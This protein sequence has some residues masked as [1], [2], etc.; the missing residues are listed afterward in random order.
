MTASDIRLPLRLAAA[1]LVSTAA[2]VPFA[3][4]FAQE[5]VEEPPTEAETPAASGGDFG[6][7]LLSG[8]R[9]SPEPLTGDWFGARSWLADHG[10]TFGI[11]VVNTVQ[12][13]VG[14]GSNEEWDNGGSAYLESQFSSDRAGL[15]PGGFLDFR[16]ERQYGGFVNKEAGSFPAVN[17]IGLFPEPDYNSFVISKLMATQFAT[18]W[19]GFFIGRF[20]TLDGDTNNLASG[21][22]RTGFL[23]PQLAFSP[24]SALTTPYVLNG[25]GAIVFTPNPLTERP[26]TLSLVFADPQVDPGDSGLNDNFFDE[27]YY[28]VEWRFPTKF[29]GL[30]GSQNI[31][32]N[33]NTKEFLQLDDLTK[34][35]IT[36]EK[37]SDSGTGVI[38]YNFHQYVYVEPGQD[39]ASIGYDADQERLQGFGIFGRVGYSDA[40][41]NPIE[42]SF[43]LG[44][45]G[46]GIIPTRDNDTFGIAPYFG[47]ISR[48][49]SDVSDQLNKNYWG[50][51]AYYN[52][53]VMPWLHVTP[54]FQVTEPL[55]DG[56]D[57]AYTLGFRAKLD[58]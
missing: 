34:Q 7:G 12:G 16:L 51:E 8:P 22:G 26:A 32:Y 11:N 37:S 24:N 27:Q 13:V 54:D 42:W 5:P 45:A 20:D 39:T 56:L 31:S 40:D 50:F 9:W 43:A 57:T 36:R 48:G 15:W 41:V 55:I 10:L 1:L 35:F 28:A 21:R 33:Y 6:T 29:F 58:L 4:G 49:V 25:V 14:G 3:E 19:L 47:T 38:A 44:L 2:L 23:S 30:P 46:R 52:I 53:A 17:M 18:E